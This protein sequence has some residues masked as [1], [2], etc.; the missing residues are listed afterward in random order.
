MRGKTNHFFCTKIV[1]KNGCCFLSHSKY[2]LISSEENETIVVLLS[3]V[4][5]QINMS[6]SPSIIVKH[7][8]MSLFNEL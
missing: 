5:V 6:N 2:V 4:N 3:K 7:V 8:K 1:E